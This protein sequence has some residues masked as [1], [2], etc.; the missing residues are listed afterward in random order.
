MSGT[1]IDDFV[2]YI[3]SPPV[4]KIASF[5]QSVATCPIE[6][7]LKEA[8]NTVYDTN[9]STAFDSTTGLITMSTNAFTTYDL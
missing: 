9:F 2:Y 5:T 6:F 3:S 7:I 1:E 8:G 4:T